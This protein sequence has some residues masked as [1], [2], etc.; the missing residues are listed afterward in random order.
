MQYSKKYKC[1]KNAVIFNIDSFNFNWEENS[2]FWKNLE[3]QYL[4]KG[5]CPIFIG[6]R[7]LPKYYTQRKHR[8]PQYTVEK[9]SIDLRG[10]TK[11]SDVFKLVLE[12]EEVVTVESAVSI[13]AYEL[14]KSCKSYGYKVDRL[15]YV[16]RYYIDM[17]KG[18]TLELEE[19]VNNRIVA[20]KK[21]PPAKSC[22][23][24]PP[25]VD[26][27]NIALDKNNP[28]EDKLISVIIAYRKRRENFTHFVNS[29]RPKDFNNISFYL[30]S[31]GDP[32]PYVKSRCGA[33]PCTAL[34]VDPP[35]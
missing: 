11:I 4:H 18:F 21:I 15:K 8:L 19:R 10:Q 20:S 5:Y 31:L 33:T 7:S 16:N 2:T 9:Q 6:L 23:S 24:T 29:L 27:S 34:V 13:I 25:K 3:K 17:F 30:V 22:V 1:P 12:A 35:A 32:D 14:K 28:S 26:F